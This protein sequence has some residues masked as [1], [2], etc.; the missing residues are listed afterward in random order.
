MTSW[1][2]RF[3]DKVTWWFIFTSSYL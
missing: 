2:L 1:R 3:H